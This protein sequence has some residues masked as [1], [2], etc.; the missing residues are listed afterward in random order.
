MRTFTILLV[1]LILTGCKNES[2]KLDERVSYWES[3]LAS[4]LPVGTSTDGI[5]K[6]GETHGIKFDDLKLQ[7]WLYANVES[8]P[9]TGIPF[10]CSAWNIIVKITIDST[11]HSVQN[12]VNIVG[13]CI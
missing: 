3:V 7:H 8:V 4:D 13:S 2:T 1:S 9:E 5:H 6:W 10:P 12:N 11:N